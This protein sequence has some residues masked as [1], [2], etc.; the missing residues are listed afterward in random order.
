MPPAPPVQQTQPGPDIDKM[1]PVEPPRGSGVVFTGSGFPTR[2][3]DIEIFLD[4]ESAGKALD[5]RNGNWFVFQVPDETK[6]GQHR[7]VVRMKSGEKAL[8]VTPTLPPGASLTV[9]HERG[10][11]VP[12]ITAVHPV[13][14]YPDKKFYS[15]EVLGE[16][17]SDNWRDDGLIFQSKG[18]LPVCW[19][20]DDT[21]WTATPACES[22]SRVYG[23]V[24]NDRQLSFRCVPRK[25]QGI[26]AL[27]VRVGQEISLPFSVTLSRVGRRWPGMIAMAFFL[28]LAA[29]IFWLARQGSAMHQIGDSRYGFFRTLLIDKE[30]DTY[31]LS[32]LQLY[33]WTAAAVLSYLY[34]AV[35]RSLV[36]MNLDFAEIPANL[37]GILLI[38]ASTGF[39]AQGIQSAKGPKGAGGLKPS[40]SDLITTGGVVAPERFQFLVWTVLGILVFLSIVF[41]QDPGTI[42][43]LPDV[44][45]SF[46]QLM[47]ISSFGYLGGKLARKTGPVIDEIMQDSAGGN[48]VL[49][50]RGR[51]LSRDASFRIDG[52]DVPAT[53]IAGVDNKATITEKDDQVDDPN[54]G[55][56]LVLTLVPP[57]A[58]WQTPPA[59]AKR[60]LTIINP[61]GQT[62]A[63]TY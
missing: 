14:G 55:K 15:F 49:T 7:V 51:G 3:E 2:P 25:Y 39:L 13:L 46:L 34:L 33:L 32:K 54:V 35:S 45:M 12:K 24:L 9:L 11:S 50:L 4:G 18:E 17:F 44:P 21:C 48:L 20:G 36:Q 52:V 60:V 23:E 22:E 42:Q 62:A 38:S 19:K 63:G 29:F 26:G 58:N 37:P 61:D 5:V 53:A 47:G 27:Q 43:G 16:G 59:G 30:T 56:I 1:E 28:L 31:S 8:P 6:L 41:L 40:P 57:L 10:K